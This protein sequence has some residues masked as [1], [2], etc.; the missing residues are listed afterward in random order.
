ML[1]VMFIAAVL[2]AVTVTIHAAGLSLVL[3]HLL[4]SHAA[5]PPQAWPITFLLIR[6]TLLLI[7]IHFAEISVWAL[8]YLWE[9]CLPDA[10]SAFYFSGVTYTT[11]GYGDA[12]QIALEAVGFILFSLV[13]FALAHRALWQQE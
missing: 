6:L 8:F 3:S 7:L 10:E 9:E 13:S 4:K 5:P 12:G 1:A 11:I 2:V